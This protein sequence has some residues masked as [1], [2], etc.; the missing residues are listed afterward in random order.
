MRSSILSIVLITATLATGCAHNPWWE[1]Q[2]S[3]WALYGAQIEIPRRAIPVP[4][5]LLAEATTWNQPVYIEAWIDSV[6]A[7]NGSWA[8]VSDGTSAPMLVVLDGRFTIPRNARGRRV[9]AWGIPVNASGQ[10]LGQD[11]TA[12]DTTVEFIAQSVLIQGFYGLEAPPAPRV[13]ELVAPKI[14]TLEVTIEEVDI[15]PVTETTP[16][17]PTEPD[18]PLIDLPD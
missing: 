2:R 10:V 9:M 17:K 12:T 16:P 18:P 15:A 14:E 8:R 1:A 11:G 13:L 4:L 6:D 3:G 7:E 5:H